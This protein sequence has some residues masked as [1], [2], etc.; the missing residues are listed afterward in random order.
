VDA[1]WT[2]VIIA[3][4]KEAPLTG[5]GE[6]RKSQYGVTERITNLAVVTE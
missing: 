1:R 4:K 5:G 6:G 3:R 2:N